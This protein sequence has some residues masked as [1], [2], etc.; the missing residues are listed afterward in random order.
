VNTL[1][2]YIRERLQKSYSS[3]ALHGGWSGI[4]TAFAGKTHSQYLFP[5]LRGRLLVD[6]HHSTLCPYDTQKHER[7][8]ACTIM[9]MLARSFLEAASMPHQRHLR[10]MK[11]AELFELLLTG[12]WARSL[13]F[14]VSNCLITL[15]RCACRPLRPRDG[16]RRMEGGWLR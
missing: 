16:G 6:T 11:R 1:K 8:L 2:A 12:N 9:A 13:D 3:P 4:L 15:K 5:S 10:S 7:I 14:T